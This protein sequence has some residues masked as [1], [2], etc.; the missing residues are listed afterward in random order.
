VQV[1]LF[2]VRGEV[3][4]YWHP[5][6]LVAWRPVVRPVVPVVLFDNAIGDSDL[7]HGDELM[8]FS[9]DGPNC[10]LEPFD[11]FTLR[12]I[13]VPLHKLPVAQECHGGLSSRIILFIGEENAHLSQVVLLA[14]A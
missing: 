13:E 3:L 6:H 10:L 1:Q 14:E 2:A 7:G 9:N 4:G 5:S 12:L 11:L 8:V